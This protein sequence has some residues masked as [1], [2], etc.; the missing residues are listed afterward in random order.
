MRGMC[1]DNDAGARRVPRRRRLS[2]SGA[3]AGHV[4]ARELPKAN[5]AW[6]V[7]A[8]VSADVTPRLVHASHRGR[9]AALLGA[10]A[11]AACAP[12]RT[13]GLR[14]AAPAQDSVTMHPEKLKAA[15]KKKASQKKKDA[16]APQA[17]TAP[18][19]PTAS[20]PAAPV[21]LAADSKAKPSAFASPSPVKSGGGDTRSTEIVLTVQEV[22]PSV[23]QHHAPAP[24]MS[25]LTPTWKPLN[26]DPRQN[27]I[28]SVASEL[29]PASQSTPVACDRA[30][31]VHL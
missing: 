14:V 21:A 1:S 19:A 15:T 18:T 13:P 5:Q 16:A 23:S 10:V 6:I 2:P 25:E 27:G 7:A 24:V 11:H 17:G 12:C 30:Y 9:S 28:K 22:S 31:S 4:S 3:M 26:T 20:T 29:A 8:P